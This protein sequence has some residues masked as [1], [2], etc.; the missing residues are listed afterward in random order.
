MIF[1]ILIYC[2]IFKFNR[3]QFNLILK[4][5]KRTQSKILEKQKNILDAFYIVNIFLIL[6][7]DRKTSFKFKNFLKLVRKNKDFLDKKKVVRKKL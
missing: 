7:F 5:K 2:V 4:T 3:I 1:N 6:F